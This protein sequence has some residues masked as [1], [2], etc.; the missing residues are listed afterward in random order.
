MMKKIV[1]TGSASGIGNALLRELC[2]DNIVFA[3]YRKSGQNNE[4]KKLSGNIIPFF[5][6]ME[7]KT[8]IKLAVNF[9]KSKTTRVDALFNVAGCVVAGA[10]EKIDV[11]DI[12]KQF[13]I[14]TFSH[15]DFSK[16]LLDMMDGGRII[17]ISS[18]SSF[19]IFPFI[20]PYCASKRALD[21]L[22]NCMQLETH[23]DIKIISVKPG[24]IATPIWEKSIEQ[25]SKSIEQHEDFEKEMRYLVANAH[26]NSKA[27]LPPEK[28][29]QLLVK[30]LNEEDPKPSYT[31]GRDAQFAE[32]FSKLPQ[33]LLNKI[34]KFTLSKRIKD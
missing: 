32:V 10:V 9:I 31:I 12:R 25:N 22:F 2:N 26:K 8:S 34:I 14:N 17:N 13:E 1:I 33:G 4:L 23:K 27:G 15:L 7:N 30:I 5:I 28:V 11:D 3:G 29:V 20:A 18:M 24:V 19:G 16:Q 21:I 6:D